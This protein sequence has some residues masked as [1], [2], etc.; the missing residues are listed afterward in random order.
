MT[1]APSRFVELS[2]PIED[3]M[4]TYPGLPA[5]VVSEHLSRAAS[6]GRYAP[7][8][9]FSIGRVEMVANTG[10]YVDAPFHRFAQGTDVAGLALAALADLPG[11]LV[12]GRGRGRALGPDLLDGLAI[13][14]RAVLF[15]TGWDSRWR[16]PEYG[17]G[18]SFVTRDAAARL[19]GERA[20]LVGIDSL[21]IDDTADLSRPAHTIL[22]ESG[23]PIVEHLTGLQGVLGRAFRFF[24]VPP[25]FAG[26]GSF[27]VRA[28][29]VLSEE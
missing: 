24:A 10:T 12:D 17:S 14:G 13:E 27:P 26:M 19:A 9:P 15:A 2:H 6:E 11:I 20:A 7:G 8:T 1:A 5:P 22:L 23:I 16:T 29:A 28:F 18:H 21:N 3:G 25:P 4:I